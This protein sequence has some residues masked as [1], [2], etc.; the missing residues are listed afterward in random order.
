M[1][2]LTLATNAVVTWTTEYHGL[3]VTALRRAGRDIDDALL[4]HIW[5]T[6][7]L[8]RTGQGSP[9]RASVGGGGRDRPASG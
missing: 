2:C 1:W 8:R 4:A 5:P 7:L 9:A 3:A 6:H